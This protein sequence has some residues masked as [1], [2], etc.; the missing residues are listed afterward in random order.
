MGE[1]GLAVHRH[2]SSDQN[3][4]FR[5]IAHLLLAL[6]FWRLS[7]A[8]CIFD[9]IYLIPN[10]SSFGTQVH[11]P[12]PW[13]PSLESQWDAK[14]KKIPF[15]ATGSLAWG[16]LSAAARLESPWCWVLTVCSP[17]CYHSR[18]ARWQLIVWAAT[19]NTFVRCSESMFSPNL[20]C[21]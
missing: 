2:Q 20:P 15:L 21:S 12:L 10:L 19:D 3:G 14:Q 5:L 11:C 6:A 4:P 18:A 9:P 7:L 1:Q 17:A 16:S 8:L 13:T